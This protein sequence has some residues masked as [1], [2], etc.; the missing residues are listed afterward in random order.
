[1]VFSN[2]ADAFSFCLSSQS[3]SP[4]SSSQ[5]SSSSFDSAGFC[6]C[7]SPSPIPLAL[8]LVVPPSP[9][10]PI[11]SKINL[12]T[13]FT[14][15][16][17]ASLTSLAPACCVSL[18]VDTNT[19]TIDASGRSP[20]ILTIFS[21]LSASVVPIK[22]TSGAVGATRSPV[23]I[24]HTSFIE[25]SSVGVISTTFE[26]P[27]KSKNALNPTPLRKLSPE[28]SSTNA[29]ALSSSALLFSLLLFL[30]CLSLASSSS[31]TKPLVI[32]FGEGVTNRA[33][34]RFDRKNRSHENK[35]TSNATRAF[36]NVF[37]VLFFLS[38]SSFLSTMCIQSVLSL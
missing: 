12:S 35:E 22:N 29:I 14:H 11:F 3:S 33:R 15:K 5:S 2:A 9:L 7:S 8:L 34:T 28:L 19:V 27:V 25:N 21:P 30:F 4:Q 13:S 37:G 32:A 23:R 10:P 31:L 24:E 16:S 18:H 20:H 6:C 38:F 36:D 1:M 26:Q 17:N